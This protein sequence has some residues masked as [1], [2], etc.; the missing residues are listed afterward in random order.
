MNSP[1]L[2]YDFRRQSG[3]Y[4]QIAAIYFIHSGDAKRAQTIQELRCKAAKK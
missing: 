2:D 1:C 3:Y 4:W